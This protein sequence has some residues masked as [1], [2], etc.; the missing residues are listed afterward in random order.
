MTTREP[1][2]ILN[3]KFYKRLNKDS[4]YIPEFKDFVE[5]SKQLVKV[6]SH[7]DIAYVFLKEYTEMKNMSLRGKLMF[8]HLYCLTYNPYFAIYLYEKY[9]DDVTW[10]QVKEDPAS[11][12]RAI[13][14][15]SY[16][17]GVGM[18]GLSQ[19]VS[20][21]EA[22]LSDSNVVEY[23]T[24]SLTD[25]PEDNYKTLQKVCGDI[26]HNGL[27][28]V[29]KHIDLLKNVAGLNIEFTDWMAKGRKF[30]GSQF[31]YDLSFQKTH[32]KV[33]PLINNKDFIT[34]LE[35]WAKVVTEILQEEMPEIRVGL[36]VSETF[37]CGFNAW[38][39]GKYYLGGDIDKNLSF[40]LGA[41]GYCEKTD[42]IY[43]ELRK[44]TMP[45]DQLGEVHGWKTRPHMVS[46][47]EMEVQR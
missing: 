40:V 29:H 3:G 35:E 17:R 42:K 39:R 26:P 32:E 33:K 8:C 28:A 31:F 11:K 2:K 18:I 37:A 44:R 19:A 45:N 22:F 4:G 24:G 1:I 10:K 5:F 30:G 6:E 12:S 41:K 46:L 36:D 7:N 34:N 27:W 38:Y 23:F 21:V 43:Y 13:K 14:I 25:N 20:D 15:G 47:M 16:R 9:G